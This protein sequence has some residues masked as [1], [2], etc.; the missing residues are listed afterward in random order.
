ML[1]DAGFPAHK[2][3]D[4]GADRAL[5]SH[6]LDSRP[7]TKYAI[8]A[9]IANP[10][11]V[12]RRLIFRLTG[13]HVGC[14]VA[15]LNLLHYTKDAEVEGALLPDMLAQ[16]LFDAGGTIRTLRAKLCMCLV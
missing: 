7:L 5:A 1:N 3:R 14:V 6:S 12:H 9:S 13:G 10:S 8:I 4:A 15:T 11:L 2:G 16:C